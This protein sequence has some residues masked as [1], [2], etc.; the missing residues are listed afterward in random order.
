MTRTMRLTVWNVEGRRVY[1]RQ[2]VEADDVLLVETPNSSFH[3][4]TRSY[5]EAELWAARLGQRFTMRIES[6]ENNAI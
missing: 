2:E 5:Q 3:L 1:F 6:E 4:Q